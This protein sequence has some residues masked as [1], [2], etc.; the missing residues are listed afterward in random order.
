MVKN[1]LEIRFPAFSCR[2]DEYKE[3]IKS[4]K[5]SNEE[6]NIGLKNEHE[7]E[8]KRLKENTEERIKY[9]IEI[10][11]KNL[12]KKRENEI[13]QLKLKYENEMNQLKNQLKLFKKSN[14]RLI[15]EENIEKNHFKKR[16]M[17][18]ET[19]QLNL[20]T[21]LSAAETSINLITT[22]HSSNVH[23][24]KSWTPITFFNQP[25]IPNASSLF[26]ITIGPLPHHFTH[27]DVNF[28]FS[29]SFN[30]FLIDI[31]FLFFSWNENFSFIK[32]LLRIFGLE[33]SLDTVGIK[34][35]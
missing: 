27:I 26:R 33:C 14:K 30:F 20:S 4:L 21:N 12:T 9:L 3:V 7:K 34:W 35:V 10:T 5:D 32:I 15:H 1:L 25:S 17:C 18:E 13:K 24:I 22:P 11:K 29:F 31:Y 16:K 6:R 2:C 8:I 28:L 23:N 19:I